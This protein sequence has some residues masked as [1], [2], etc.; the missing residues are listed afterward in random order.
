MQNLIEY[1]YN[2]QYSWLLEYI[3]KCKSGEITI[4]HEL[5][6]QL[7][8]L[9]EHFNDPQITIDFADAHKRI[10]FIETKCKHSEAPFAGKPFT[11]LLYQ[12]AFI[13]AIYSFKIYDEEI[14]REVRLYQDVLFLVGRKW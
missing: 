14:G 13:E 7:D 1:T 11:L 2:G 9:L 10:K 3:K 12:K 8:M 6:L 5:M 4:G